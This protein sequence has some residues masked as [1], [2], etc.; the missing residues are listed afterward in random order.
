MS[1]RPPNILFLMDDQHRFDGF[2]FAGN[3]WVET[4][5]LDAL[6]GD[7]VVFTNAYT[8]SPVCVPA[9]Q[10]LATGNLPSTCGV[11]VY[12]QDLPPGSETFARALARAGY[13]TACAGKLHHMGLDQMQG[14]TR[15]VCN[16]DDMQVEPENVADRDEG[17]YQRHFQ[18][19]ANWTLAEELRRAG[20]G[21]SPYAV[22]DELNVEGACGLLEEYFVSPHYG[23]ATPE[24]PLLL[25]VSLQ[26]PHYPFCAPEGLYR[27]YF[28][29]VEIFEE[30]GCLEHPAFRNWTWKSEGDG[31]EARRR[32]TAAT[33]AMIEM[34][35][36]LFGRVL[37]KIAACGQDL[38]DWLVIYTSDHGEMLGEH[39]KWWKLSFYEGS[40]KVPLVMRGPRLFTGGGRRVAA[41]VSLCDLFATLVEI[42]G[43]KALAGAGRDSRSLWP[44]LRQEAGA[45]EAW[46][47][48]VVSQYGGNACLVKRGTLKYQW[49]GEE[50][51]E[52]LFDLAEDPGE[53]RNVIGEARY[54]AVVAEMRGRGRGGWGSSE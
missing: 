26:Q 6:A 32:A 21:K 14:W 13:T 3:G 50:R 41:N 40:V 35:D 15:R 16:G 22:S 52:V 17:A 38:D 43:A 10:C 27:K 23:R 44:M 42:G 46:P 53:T 24:R 25:K 30:Q 36:T 34:T 9:R 37:D 7:G 20:A 48:E 2:G 54:A 51:E 39:D 4:P 49:Y 33:A 45:A 12:G 29:R 8:P 47:D 31:P 18:K 11:E 1:S 28:D 5:R 19:A